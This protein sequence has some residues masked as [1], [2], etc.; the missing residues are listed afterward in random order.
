MIAEL[1]SNKDLAP[2]PLRSILQFAK[3][4][5]GMRDRLLQQDMT[6]SFYCRNGDIQMH[7]GRVCYN[8]SVWLMLLE[9]FLQISFHGIASEFVI[10]QSRFARA[11]Q[12]QVFLSKR[13]QITKM[14]AADR[15]KACDEK[16]HE[17][18]L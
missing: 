2:R 4:F 9:R 15:T 8:D 11:K 17:S 13:D 16:F 1:K 3:L 18:S 7:G 5:Q 6:S 10:W 14:S 12:D